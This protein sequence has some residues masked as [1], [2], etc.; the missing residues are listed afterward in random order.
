MRTSLGKTGIEVSRLGLSAS[1]RPGK[2]TI[3][4]AL[5]EG[6][7]YFFGYGFDGQMTSAMRDVFTTKRKEI[8]LATG[9]YNLIWM[10]PNL[11]RTLEKRLRQ[12]KTDY[13][14][15]FLFLGV[16]K[17]KEFP[18]KALEEIH[19]FKEEGKSVPSACHATIENLR[20]R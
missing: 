14:D 6:V 8:V 9:A 20:A 13:I 19:R 1:Y 18:P 7:N 3:Y 17:P 12:F 10:Y 15:V 16:M 5:D 2:K 4:K 11:R